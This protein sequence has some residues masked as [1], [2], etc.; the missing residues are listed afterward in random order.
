MQRHCRTIFFGGYGIGS[1]ATGPNGTVEVQQTFTVN[2]YDQFTVTGNV[3]HLSI[4]HSRLR[5]TPTIDLIPNTA[6][7]KDTDGPQTVLLS[8]IDDGMPGGSQGLSIIAASSNP[9]VIPT[10]TVVYHS[11]DSTGSLWYHATRGVTGISTITVTVTNDGGTPGYPGDDSSV[12]STFTARVLAKKPCDAGECLAYVGE[13]DRGV[14][15]VIDVTTNKILRNVPVSPLLGGLELAIAP[16]GSRLY[17]IGNTG[18]LPHLSVVDTAANTEIGSV[19]L[20]R[21]GNALALTPDGGRV[22]VSIPAFSPSGS[23]IVVIDTAANAVVKTINLGGSFTD[24]V[25]LSP[26][27]TRAFVTIDTGSVLVLDTVSYSVLQT[28]RWPAGRTM[29]PCPETDRASM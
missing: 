22:F 13:R 3:F 14:V 7:V 28:T 16:D 24:G 10:P 19:P 8:G 27:R 15:Q 26:T 4:T 1:L 29:R 17:A 12:A 9:S 23:Q 18:G 25:V 5:Y 11:G 2:P 21:D 6:P 20:P